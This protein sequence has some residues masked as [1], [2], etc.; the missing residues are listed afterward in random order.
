MEGMDDHPSVARLSPEDFLEHDRA[1]R[2]YR[3][4]Q[5]GGDLYG[6]AL[7]GRP[8]FTM[9]EAERMRKDPQVQFALR[10][11][12]A[13][14]Y[15]LKVRV[16][17]DTPRVGKYVQEQ[18]QNVWDHSLRRML[19]ST[20]TY[21]PAV[22]ETTHRTSR[23]R[24]VFERWDDIHPRD[25]L[26]L[27]WKTGRHRGEWCGVQVK[28]A[29]AAGTNGP[30]AGGF[31]LRVPHA[32]W[33]SG[34][35]EYGS[36]WGRPRMAGAHEPW[37][38]KRGRHGAVDCRRLWFKKGAFSGG[39]MRY[40]LGSTTVDNGDG[41]TSRV[42]NQ[43]LAREIVERYETGGVLC[44][45]NT[46][47]PNTKEF[48][49][50]FDPPKPG[51]E[52]GN[53]LEYPKQLDREILIGAGV[54]PEMVEAAT[55]G[56][57]YSGRSIPAQVFFASLD[58]VAVLL[59]DAIER[60]ILR[61]MVRLNFR[62]ARYKLRPESLAAMVAQDPAQAGKMLQ[63]PED[64]PPHAGAGG[65]FAGLARNGNEKVRRPDGK[66]TYRKPGVRLSH[67]AGQDVVRS[68]KRLEERLARPL[69]LA[70]DAGRWITIGGSKGADGKRHGGSPVFVRDGK[71]VKGHPSLTGKKIDS[72]KDAADTTHRQELH[73]SKQHEVA[74]WRKKAR[75]AGHDP[76]HLDQLAAEVKA[77]HDAFAAE[78]KEVLQYA[79]HYATANGLGDL[80]RRGKDQRVGGR[81]DNQRGI[82]QVAE[83]TV[84]QF[85]HHFREETGEHGNHEDQLR[86]MLAEGNP[87]P[88]SHAEAYSQ[89]FDQM[90]TDRHARRA[91]PEPDYP[92]EWDEPV[93]LGWQAGQTRDGKIKAVG[94]GEKEGKSLYGDDARRALAQGGAG[95]D[96]DR[97]AAGE[98][99]AP[100]PP[101]ASE[102]EVRDLA[103][104][105]P[106]EDRGAW[107]KVKETYKAIRDAVFVKTTE[108]AYAL[109]YELVPAVAD[110]AE[111]YM[112]G[113]ASVYGDID[114]WK[115]TTGISWSFTMT[116]VKHAVSIGFKLAG[117]KAPDGARLS[118]PD[119]ATD[120]AA[121]V[122]V[123]ALRAV[124]RMAG[125]DVPIDESAVR[126]LLAKRLGSGCG[127]TRLGWQAA[128]TRDGGDKAIGYGDNAGQVLYGERARVA[129]AAQGTSASGPAGGTGAAEKNADAGANDPASAHREAAAALVAPSDLPPGLKERYTGI[130]TGVLDR[131]SDGCRREFH[132]NVKGATFYPTLT[133]LRE[134][135]RKLTGEDE[136]RTV[137]ITIEVEG[138]VHLHLN[139][140]AR[141]GTAEYKTG[142]I[143]AHEAGHA[144]DAGHR[145]SG[146][147]TW[148]SAWRREVVKGKI[149]LSRGALASASE[150]FA[151]FHR[152]LIQKGSEFARGAFPKCVA[153]FESKGLL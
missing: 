121:Q 71:I 84:G 23:G 99:K 8:L 149:L 64:G 6:A 81:E 127:P 60:H 140:D 110:T 15:Q 79:R 75:K 138:G 43:D 69:R 124:G 52:V 105:V 126:E 2:L 82:D 19:T 22:G 30:A 9:R 91:D 145:F 61:P 125:K 83:S 37:L 34:E 57:G 100:E 3:P 1:T 117:H 56:S 72:L 118:L 40:P 89:A 141:V 51:G 147:K 116:L 102:D 94:T 139:G 17:A 26:P 114:A 41:T 92:A 39:S 93:R 115:H 108:L 5:A 68:L 128:K 109:T 142:G 20:F 73:S 46:R 129:L 95:K 85:P 62:N 27:E 120:A 103:Y 59:I 11:L 101:E 134:A 131:M 112:T 106:E 70:H 88:L 148:Q 32:F 151:E 10:I 98:H 143:Y 49:W 38:E 14:L 58:E 74:A 63:S 119:G 28:A 66:T 113:R 80:N 77:H 123:A 24:V 4:F 122:V 29:A 152:L 137:G 55:V 35:A 87:E 76:K 136:R 86:A 7:D 48:L 130:L 97:D 42:N 21:G 50:V 47:D 31:E 25:A 153:F 65:M 78:R 53:I 96:G 144:I 36:Y 12:R 132:A 67:R 135:V 107:G 16:E 104:L 90:E 150:G 13:P 54:V 45:P 133:A 33:F 18:F 111:D 146:D 44:L